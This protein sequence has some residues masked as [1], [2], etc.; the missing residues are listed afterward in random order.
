MS[1]LLILSLTSLPA[2]YLL[3]A[4]GH[5]VSS[6]PVGRPVRIDNE[7]FST[8]RIDT[9]GFV[10]ITGSLKSVSEQQFKLSPYILVER[11]DWVYSE[12]AWRGQM[13]PFHDLLI[14]TYPP[15]RD[16][17]SWYFEVEHSLAGPITLQSGDQIDFEI[18]AYPLKSGIYHVHSYFISDEA[19]F[20]GRGQTIVVTGSAVPT[21]GEVTQLYLPFAIGLAAG[22][23]LILQAAS[24]SRK[25]NRLERTVRIF[26]A[27]KSSF[28][29]AWLSGVLFWLATTSYISSVETRF[30]LV[31]SA[32]AVLAS[33]TFGGYAASIVKSRTRHLKFAVGTSVATAAFYF[34]LT[35]SNTFDQ[36]RVPQFTPDAFVSFVAVVVNALVATYLLI[37]QRRERGKVSP[38][39]RI[40]SP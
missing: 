16:V 35:F 3:D 34:I 6:G 9:D 1:V 33:I 38:T 24:V 23:I 32:L 31:L 15:Y 2:I 26:F 25:Q 20:W 22:T 39:N 11:A 19:R 14:T 5:G 4:Y 28:E 10:T 37:V 12:G 8:N 7:Q 29:T 40:A 27:A 21:A 36:Y 17:A 13:P 18:R 30:V